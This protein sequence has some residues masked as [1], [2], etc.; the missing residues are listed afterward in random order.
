MSQRFS[1]KEALIACWFLS[2]SSDRSIDKDEVFIKDKLMKMY[3]LYSTDWDRFM[4][5]WAKWDGTNGFDKI[6][7]HCKKILDDADYS[8]RVKALA[9]MWA[10]YAGEADY[11]TNEW[12]AEESKYYL[13]ME[14]ALD[15]K[16]KDVVTEYIKIDLFVNK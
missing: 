10:I 4:F 12:S 3:D 16:R 14:K 7:N 2:I 5:K 15:V 13:E 1:Q 8:I 9:G 6:F 11:E